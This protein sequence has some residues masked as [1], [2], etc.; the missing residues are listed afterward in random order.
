MSLGAIDPPPGFH[1]KTCLRITRL[2]PLN[3]HRPG[4]ET[5][6]P[7][8]IG[9]EIMKTLWSNAGDTSDTLDSN[10]AA[11]TKRNLHAGLKAKA[12]RSVLRVDA[13][14]GHISRHTF[15]SLGWKR[16]RDESP[17]FVCKVHAMR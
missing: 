16:R 15:K 7:K 17:L 5:K 11:G 9:T 1:R 6:Q 2:E 3:L 8:K 10:R 12:R 14:G 4:G 13:T